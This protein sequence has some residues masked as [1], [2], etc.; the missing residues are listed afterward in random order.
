MDLRA[1]RTGCDLFVL[2]SRGVKV[3]KNACFE[4]RALFGI[5][6]PSLFLLRVQHERRVVTRSAVYALPAPSATPEDGPM[7]QFISLVA[8]S[9]A[10]TAGA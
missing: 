7:T 8:S 3:K 6:Q 4:V 1:L 5:D 10:S 9:S 2:P